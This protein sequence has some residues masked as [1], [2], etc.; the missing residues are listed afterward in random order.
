MVGTGVMAD[1]GVAAEPAPE[2]PELSSGAEAS[3]WA[4]RNSFMASPALRANF[5]SWLPPNST[6]TA[7][8]RT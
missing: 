3:L 7:I 4:L 2:G 6:T 1:A 5:G 8:I